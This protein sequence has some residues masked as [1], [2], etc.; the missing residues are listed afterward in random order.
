MSTRGELPPLPK[1]LSGTSS[2]EREIS[3]LAGQLESLKNALGS[4]YW[5]NN[6]VRALQQE[7]R[8]QL[9]GYNAWSE[10]GL[11]MHQR[12]RRAARLESAYAHLLWP[13]RSNQ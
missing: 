1:P 7:L 6:E 10:D 2:A 11:P 12:A 13:G 5:D 3:K 8:R 4:E 9:S